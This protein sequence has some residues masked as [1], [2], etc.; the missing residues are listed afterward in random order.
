MYRVVVFNGGSD[1]NDG[2]SK[3]RIY[4]KEVIQQMF[5]GRKNTSELPRENAFAVFSYSKRYTFNI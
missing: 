1:V 3:M 5:V 4:S 2:Y